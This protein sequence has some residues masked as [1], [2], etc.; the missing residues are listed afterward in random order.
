MLRIAEERLGDLTVVRVAGRLGGAGVEELERV[1]AASLRP[2]RIDLAALLQADELGIALLRSLR[3][4]GA[5]LRVCL[6]SSVC[7][8]TAGR[9]VPQ[10]DGRWAEFL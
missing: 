2:L 3:G 8:S 7:C 1:C 5:E 10:G 9:V 6:R 4:S